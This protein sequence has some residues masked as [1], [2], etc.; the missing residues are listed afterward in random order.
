MMAVYVGGAG[1]AIIGGLYWKKGTTAG[2]TS[3]LFT[4]SVGWILDHT[5][6]SQRGKVAGVFR[7][8]ADIRTQR[9][10][11]IPV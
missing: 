10:E 3:A 8:A 6:Q 11:Q 9:L 5:E 1:A 4:G 7:G 2:A